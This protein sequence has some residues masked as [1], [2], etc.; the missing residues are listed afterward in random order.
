MQ[1]TWQWWELQAHVWGCGWRWGGGSATGKGSDSYRNSRGLLFMRPFDL[2]SVFPPSDKC[3]CGMDILMC[4]YFVCTSFFRLPAQ[5]MLSH[6]HLTSKESFAQ[7]SSSAQH[8]D[9]DYFIFF[10]LLLLFYSAL[11]MFFYG[12]SG[13]CVHY[14]L[15]KQNNI[16]EKI[17]W[18]RKRERGRD[19]QS[20]DMDI[21]A[22]LDL[23]LRSFDLSNRTCMK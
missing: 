1:T 12:N 18:M 13:S 17:D 23:S 11:Y 2:H 20:Q 19:W 21:V 15:A 5:Q 6:Q 7:C 10:S 14:V 8:L 3:K 9:V 22:N 16:W 4:I